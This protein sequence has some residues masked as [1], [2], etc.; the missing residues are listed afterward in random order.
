M[1]IR[2]ASFLGRFLSLYIR[3]KMRN[4]F[5]MRWGSKI[6]N[7]FVAGRLWIFAY[8]GPS[9]EEFWV[10]LFLKIGNFVRLFLPR[11]CF[12]KCGKSV[13]KVWHFVIF[14]IFFTFSLHFATFLP[15]KSVACHVFENKSVATFL[16]IY[17]RVFHF[18]HVFTLFF[19]I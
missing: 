7:K 16:G 5:L 9:R 2:R 10:F 11:F 4:E 6:S 17:L 14:R 1:P 8:P 15:Q 12:E 3:Q 19:F 13:A 18:C